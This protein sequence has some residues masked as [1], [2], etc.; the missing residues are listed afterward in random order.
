MEKTTGGEL[1]MK[2]EGKR[3][4]VRGKKKEREGREMEKRSKTGEKLRYLRTS[5]GWRN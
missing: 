1:E 3:D 4:G 2:G 5:S